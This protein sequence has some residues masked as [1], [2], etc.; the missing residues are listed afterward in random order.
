[1][2]PTMAPPRALLKGGRIADSRCCVIT[3]DTRPVWLL[4]GLSVVDCFLAHNTALPHTREV[5]AVRR[6]ALLC[7]PP[8]GHCGSE[9]N[10]GD[11]SILGLNIVAY[12]EYIL[13]GMCQVGICG[14]MAGHRPG[15]GCRGETDGSS[16]PGRCA[17][18]GGVTR[19]LYGGL[20]PS[21]RE[22]PDRG[23]GTSLPATRGSQRATLSASPAG[24][25]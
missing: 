16:S 20:P 19:P 17:A 14:G 1:M 5:T 9:E 23:P 7:R 4:T 22:P 11:I 21:S 15:P 8:T 18:A 25:A 10:L 13:S 6:T 12:E 2:G 24:R 3:I